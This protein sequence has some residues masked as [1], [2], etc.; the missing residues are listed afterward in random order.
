MA[1]ADP[2]RAS[3]PLLGATFNDRPPR[4]RKPQAGKP[5]VIIPAGVERQPKRR[6]PAN[7]GRRYAPTPPDP[8]EVAGLLAA[9][10]TVYADEWI[11]K[12]HQALLIVLWRTGM[13]IFEALALAEHD[14]DRQLSS[15]LIRRGKGGRRR[16]VGIDRWA[17]DYL[18]PWLD[19]RQGLPAGEVFCV[20]NG[21]TAGRSID[22]SWVRR[23]MPRLAGAAGVRKRCAP[24]QLRHAWTS[25]V[26]REQMPLGYV[27][28]GLGHASLATTTKYAQ[29]LG[30]DE[31]V[32][33]M[34]NRPAPM[35]P[36][37]RG[38]L[39]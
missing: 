32:H 19:I 14:L 13:R 36:A 34:A 28:H 20:I 12:R 11:I 6:P 15:I 3:A 18:D 30:G 38:L 24:H 37:L 5:R 2:T 39:E 33:A 4:R 22:A 1:T 9:C 8:G 10:Q 26:L 31:T 23:S 17:W 7:K 29:A 16:V 21:P 27:M 35:T 25:D